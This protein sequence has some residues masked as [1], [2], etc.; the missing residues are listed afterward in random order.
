[1]CTNNERN[2]L[3][4]YN[5]KKNSINNYGGFLCSNNSFIFRLLPEQMHSI[6]LTKHSPYKLSGHV[7]WEVHPKRFL[8]H[9]KRIEN[10]FFFLAPPQYNNMFIDF[11]SAA[12]VVKMKWGP[13]LQVYNNNIVLSSYSF[14]TARITVRPYIIFIFRLRAESFHQN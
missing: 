14:C 7:I 9:P 10:I 3:Y 8:S 2:R 12:L 6:R 11:N 13:A 1:M 4:Y 5:T